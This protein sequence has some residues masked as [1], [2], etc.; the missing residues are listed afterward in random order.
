MICKT[1]ADESVGLGDVGSGKTVV[2]VIGILL[3][4]QAIKLH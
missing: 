3:F 4:N 1:G 2:A